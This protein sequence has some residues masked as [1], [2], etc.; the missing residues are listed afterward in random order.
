MP[1]K[2]RV[3]EK[4]FIEAWEKLKSPSALSK[5][6][7]VSERNIH[8]RRRSIENRTKIKLPTEAV[9]YHV[10]KARHNAGLTDGI[11]LVFSDAHFWPGIRS[12]AFKGLLWAI[13]EL[14]PHVVVNNGDAFD[15][16]SISRYPRIGWTSRPN[17]KQELQACQDALKEIEEACEK[18]RHHTQLI[19]PMGNHDSRFETRLAQAAPEFEGVGGTALKDHFLK[20][21]PCWSCWLSDN[22]VIK[23][24]Y[25]SGI[26]ATHNNTVNSGTTIV[27][28]HLHSLKVTPFGDYNGTRWGVDT[29]TLAEIDGPQF[30][31]YLEDSPVNWRSGFAVLTMKDNKL[32][33]PE[34]VSKHDEGIIDFRGSLIDVSNL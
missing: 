12:T 29:G 4:E 11:A 7:G 20:W 21:H 26:H 34:L 10:E 15:G 13:K 14:K 22:I 27:T 30:L 8:T 23:H 17:V 24:R 28:G 5:L 25:K 9:K 19:W 18:A 3:S 31:D 33:W 6:F 32:L 1:I 2:H 16:A